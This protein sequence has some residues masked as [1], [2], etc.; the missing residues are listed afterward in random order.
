MLKAQATL[1]SESNFFTTSVAKVEKD[2]RQILYGRSERWAT[3]S[4]AGRPFPHFP[5]FFPWCSI[6]FPSCWIE[7]FQCRF[8][9]FNIK[10]ETSIN[11]EIVWL[12]MVK[13]IW[14]KIAAEQELHL[15]PSVRLGR[16]QQAQAH[17][18]PTDARDGLCWGIL[19]NRYL[20]RVRVES[21]LLHTIND[22]ND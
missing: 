6:V 16:Q 17:H 18:H 11:H 14:L 1:A 13:Q 4:N 12:P 3:A 5:P 21:Q 10:G 8:I 9:H 20:Q 2:I 19:W 15:D 7:L 22:I